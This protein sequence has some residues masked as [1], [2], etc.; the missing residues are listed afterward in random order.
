[1]RSRIVGKYFPRRFLLITKRKIATLQ[2]QKLADPTLTKWFKS[3][4]I[5]LT[6]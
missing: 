5:V 6:N 1:M 2:R 4:S 3:T